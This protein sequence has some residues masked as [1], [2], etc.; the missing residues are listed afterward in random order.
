MVKIN[1]LHNGLKQLARS[2]I[3]K[4]ADPAL[5]DVMKIAETGKT[6]KVTS[7]I[8]AIKK[9]YDNPPKGK[10]TKK[11][12]S[13][14]IK[15][16]KDE[17]HAKQQ[18]EGED[19][20][21]KQQN[22]NN[23][24][25]KKNKKRNPLDD[26]L[27]S[28]DD[29][30]NEEEEKQGYERQAKVNPHLNHEAE[31]FAD[32]IIYKR[33]DID[34]HV[35]GMKG[36]WFYNADGEK[37]DFYQQKNHMTVETCNHIKEYE[38]KKTY[39]F[40][41]E[42]EDLIFIL[43]KDANFK[44]YYEN[45]GYVNNIFVMNIRPIP[46]HTYD[47]PYLVS[48]F[49][50]DNFNDELNQVV[51]SKYIKYFINK[52]A[53]EFNELFQIKRC[54]YVEQNYKPNS[55]F[56]NEI[57]NCFYK[58]FNVLK[59]DG[60][61]KFKELTYDYLLNILDIPNN[62]KSDIGLSICRAI[63]KFFIPF[64]LGLD[65]INSND[66]MIFKFRTK[67]LNPSMSTNIMRIMIT[68]DCHIILLNNNLKSLDQI[69]G[70]VEINYDI[71]DIDKIDYLAL[72][73]FIDDNLKK[74]SD[75]FY[76]RK[77]IKNNDDKESDSEDD[78]EDEKEDKKEEKE[79]KKDESE[80]ICGYNSIH[81]IKNLDDL[82][83]IFN[84]I[85]GELF[86]QKVQIIYNDR[87]ENLLIDMYN[88]NHTPI[89]DSDHGKVKN[90]KLYKP[91]D[92]VKKTKKHDE[93]DDK[94]ISANVYSISR[95]G[96]KSANDTEI[97]IDDL[98]TIINFNIQMDKLHSSLF[99][100]EH[101]SYYHDH[102][103]KLDNY[104]NIGPIVGFF[105]KIIPEGM[106]NAMD[107][108]K[109]YTFCMS[110]IKQIPIFD[111]FDLYFLYNGLPIEP[112][113]KYIIKIN[114]TCN[115]SN[116]LFQ[117]DYNKCFGFLLLALPET[118]KYDIIY[119]Q[120][121]SKI[122]D[123][124]FKQLIDDLY[125]CQISD[126]KAFDLKLKKYIANVCSG[127]LEKKYNR[128]T[129]TKIF[130]DH[131]DAYNYAKM[132]GAKV[133]IISKYDIDQLDDMDIE[134]QKEL[135]EIKKSNKNAL[136]IDVNE[137]IDD[138][139]YDKIDD[140]ENEL[141][142]NKL[143]RE[144]KVKE[145]DLYCVTV[146]Y[147]KQLI[148]N[149][150]DIKN[151]IYNYSHI[152]LLKIYNTMIENNIEPVGINTDCI[153]Y[154]PTNVDMSK[155]FNL[156]LGMGNY[157]IEHNKYPI[158][159]QFGLR[160]NN[161]LL[162]LFNNTVINHEI[163]DEYNNEEFKNIFDQYNTLVIG[164]AGTGKSKS[165][166]NYDK[167]VLFITP[168]NKLSIENR[169]VEI[170]SITF[171]KL[172]GMGVTENTKINILEYD[173]SGYSSIV[174]DEIYL[175]NP[176]HL[177]KID[178]FIKKHQDKKIYGTGDINQ[179]KSFGYPLN[180]IDNMATYTNHCVNTIF[181]NQ[182]V[183]K[184]NK[185][186]KDPKERETLQN[187]I[188]DLF[189]ETKNK[190]II[191]LL[192]SYEFK[193]IENLY[194]IIS[195]KNIAYYNYKV[196]LINQHV[197]KNIV[198]IPNNAIEVEHIKYGKIDK[199]TKKR[200]IKK[201]WKVSYYKGVE[202]IAKKHMTFKNVDEKLKIDGYETVKRLRFYNNNNYYIHEINKKYVTLFEESEKVCITLE[203][204]HLQNFI[205]SFANTC[206]SMQGMGVDESIT[207]CD[208]DLDCVDINFVYTAITRA[209]SLKNVTILLSSEY[210][211]NRAREKMIT[212][213]FKNKI[214]GY[215][216]QDRIS[217]RLYDKDEYIDIEYIKNEIKCNKHCKKCNVK[218]ITYIK[219]ATVNSN[220]SFN[221]LDNSIAHIKNNLEIL[222]VECN[223]ALSNKDNRLY[224]NWNKNIEKQEIKTE[225]IK[226]EA[227]KTKK[228]K[229]QE[230]IKPIDTIDIT[231]PC[232]SNPNL[233]KTEKNNLLCINCYRLY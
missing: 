106:F 83:E 202:L 50:R 173:V 210:D 194:Q 208:I 2:K 150:R 217:K 147:E 90:I 5:G 89:V 176:Y 216:R 109:C 189:D 54:Q 19:K 159:N 232:C 137:N 231:K 196:D 124:N 85:E 221:R 226:T 43:L 125:S 112:L 169:K 129:H 200:K 218:F 77:T 111:Y 3:M 227:I 53:K 58:S 78:E 88:Q 52:D 127:L 164:P 7:Y 119:V 73:K 187:L 114:S 156:S 214:T 148:T 178:I 41:N 55:C 131:N 108:Q 223:R 39:D 48:L 155:I 10:I 153:L 69:K 91:H 128:K 185:R 16:M 190:D 144:A 81:V 113:N 170:E 87:L 134:L 198:G 49:E 140:I 68:D 203:N 8:N 145:L 97:T 183:L 96:I 195:K 80:M 36:F 51:C 32:I 86:D 64:N 130:R 205:F 71:K 26:G 149:F 193:F 6:E 197:H 18:T 151:M 44:E 82:M 138:I 175:Y 143:K 30:D 133:S 17:E 70:K 123:V 93:E 67:K 177:S 166:K 230:I 75:K 199:K 121:P 219:E 92:K 4:F 162:E 61:R 157:K 13:E 213:Y 110:L 11:T 192:R 180:N 122:I 15:Q 115:I 33:I 59:S 72:N 182:I 104:Y 211:K 57:I 135:K 139:I 136:D 31:T 220:I 24:S 206:H 154:K 56:I 158:K 215:R 98:P 29:S 228:I 167:N 188:N 12:I 186:L 191:G 23:D 172:N 84:E 141:K 66:V 100:K 25:K 171:H 120:K 63:E 142:N 179:L 34:D 174:F 21:K 40:Q 35:K 105:G 46:F 132:Y 181:N 95:L 204:D 28:S 47:Y 94:T 212:R 116:M 168:F 107:M 42:F 146:S 27:S 22:N 99:I 101:I 160:T 103:L 229:K 222:C 1:K 76:L 209:T 201:Q 163:I 161:N 62:K 9:I 152:E 118:V 184:I 14:M 102:T 207:V 74:V 165:L 225:K 224:I 117:T 126:D 65:I 60:K 79:D 37:T 38:N 233:K 20:K 45:T